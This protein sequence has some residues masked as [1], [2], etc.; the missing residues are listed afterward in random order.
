[1]FYAANEKHISIVELLLNRGA[2]L[3][4]GINQYRFMHWAALHG[5]LGVVERIANRGDDIDSK[6]EKINH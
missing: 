6:D 5:F 1:M 2:R 3:L 4:N